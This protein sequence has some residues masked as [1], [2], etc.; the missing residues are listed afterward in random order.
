MSNTPYF[1]SYEKYKSSK[2]MFGMTF[3]KEYLHLLDGSKVLADIK[4]FDKN[5]N[6]I[7]W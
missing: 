1:D 3:K 4:I 5:G 7:D 2:T 6:E